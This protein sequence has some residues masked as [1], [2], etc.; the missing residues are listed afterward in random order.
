MANMHLPSDREVDRSIP[1]REPAS[2]TGHLVSRLVI[3]LTL[4]II[5]IV[6]LILGVELFGILAVLAG[7]IALVADRI[8]RLGI[9]SQRDR[10]REDEARRQMR[11]HGRWTH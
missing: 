11:R 7:V 9:V 6:L 4:V 5:G 10:D 3:P 8:I 2:R 1:E